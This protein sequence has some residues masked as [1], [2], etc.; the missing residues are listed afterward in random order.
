MKRATKIISISICLEVVLASSMALL[1]DAGGSG[2]AAFSLGDY[3]TYSY[4]GE[5]SKA[6]VSEDESFSVFVHGEATC[7]KDFPASPSKAEITSR[8]IARHQV[9]GAEVTL[10]SGYTVTIVPFPAKK[11]D[12]SRIERTVPLK[13]PP[14]SEPGI[15]Q[16]VSE[17]ERATLTIPFLGLNEVTEYLPQS[18]VLGTVIYVVPPAG[19]SVKTT[20]LTGVISHQGIFTQEIV[21]YSHDRDC[22]LTIPK[23]TV[24]LRADGTPLSEITMVEVIEPPLPQGTTRVARI[25][26]LE[27]DGATFEPPVTLT[28]KYDPVDI[29]ENVREED[30]VVAYYDAETGEWVEL[31]SIVYV[32]TNT[33][34]ADVA[35]FTIFAIIAA[36]VIQYKLVISS[37]AGGSV[38]TP[39]EGTFTYDEGTA[40]NL[41]AKP[42]EGYQFVNWTGD[43]DT[44]AN[45]NAT[46]TTTTMDGNYS[47]RANFEAIVPPE[48]LGSN[49]T[50]IGGAI[51]AVVVVGLGVF[52]VRRR[53]ASQ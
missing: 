42:D 17:L 47:L 37:T 35:H 15:Y 46:Q 10:N 31:P 14:R 44:I 36:P 34:T 51:A 22:W 53:R 33:I 21:A 1:A 12:M 38:T 52:F 24:G 39:G 27:P 4:Q 29:P 41:V 49:W 23:D 26:D 40:V 13:F 50:L 45:V 19:A 30:L 48:E 9:S 2:V 25:Y 18:K 6:E 32:E 8:V 43:V 16:V 7:T 20:K 3:F 11:G 5:L 28:W